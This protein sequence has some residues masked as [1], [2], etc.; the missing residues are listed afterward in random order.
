MLR[1]FVRDVIKLFSQYIV[2]S[3]L[4][5]KCLTSFLLSSYLSHWKFTHEM[6]N[7]K[8]FVEPKGGLVA[9]KQ[10]IIRSLIVTNLGNY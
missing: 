2:L 9:S 4:C 8:G 10:L 7:T 3:V 1:S 5:F 6:V